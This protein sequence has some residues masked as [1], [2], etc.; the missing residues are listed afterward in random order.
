[1]AW[2]R[3]GTARV[4]VSHSMSNQGNRRTWGA[5]FVNVFSGVLAEQKLG[6]ANQAASRSLP[7]AERYKLGISLNVTFGIL[8]PG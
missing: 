7:A 6:G 1:M 8:P 4:R 3:K 2:T 5:I